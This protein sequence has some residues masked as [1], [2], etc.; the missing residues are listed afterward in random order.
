MALDLCL[1][2]ACPI[3][4]ETQL[5]HLLAELGLTRLWKAIRYITGEE[6][7]STL[8]CAAERKLSGQQWQSLDIQRRTTGG[9]VGQAKNV[10]CHG[11]S[12]YLTV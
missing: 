10:H 12:L 11:R 4:L 1:I 6:V 7:G 5:N 3:L 9:D 2:R 8:G